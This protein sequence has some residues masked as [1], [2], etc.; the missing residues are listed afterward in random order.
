MAGPTPVSALIHAA[1]MVAAG[2]YLVGRFFPVFTDEA[3]LYIA[4]TGGITLFIAA[5]IAMVQTDYKKVLAYSTVSQLGHMFAA[6]GVGA[7]GF[8]IFHLMTHAFFKA[9]LFLGAGSVIHAM[10]GEQDMRQMGGLRHKLPITY[11]T[12]LAATLAIGGVPPFAGF[13]SKDGIIWSAFASGHPIIW[14]LLLTGAGLTA[15]YMFRQLYLTFFGDFRGTHEQQHHLH[16]SAVSMVSVLG[17]LGGL[18][19]VGGIVM[20]PHFLGD[21]APLRDF[22]SPV[23][24]SPQTRLLATGQSHEEWEA[25]FA[26]L[27]VVIVGLGWLLADVTY[28]QKR[29]DPRILTDFAGGLVYRLSFN[30]YYIDELYD[31]IIVQPYLIATRAFAWFDQHIIDGLVNLTGTFIRFGAWLSGLFDNYV[32]DGL[33]NLAANATLASGNRLRRLQTGSINGYLYGILAGV[34]LILLARAILRA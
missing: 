32:V 3:L 28:R 33:V 23:F 13:I 6:A 8:A 24:G 15:F 31:R 20:L 11:W 25:Y 5:T 19:V 17:V 18:S 4:Y 14:L 16:E 10:S 34:M 22:L 27:S 2:V 1:T 12:F 26:I 7:F 21:F 9:C 29:L 30:K